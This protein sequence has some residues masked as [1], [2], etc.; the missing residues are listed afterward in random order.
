MTDSELLGRMRC[1]DQSAL[2]EIMKKYKRLVEYIAAKALSSESDREETVMD[3]FYK[4]WD[5]RDIIDL[6]KMS[7]KSYISMT[8]SSCTID[9]LRKITKGEA[10]DPLEDD[11]ELDLDLENEAA[12]RINLDIVKSCVQAMPSPDREVF[13]DRYYFELEVKEIAVRRGLK[14]KKVWNILSRRKTMLRKELIKGGVIL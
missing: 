14:E 12:R 4:V 5:K 13:I 6:E 10:V 3:T 1:N 8:A 9:K 11:L 7:L 2:E